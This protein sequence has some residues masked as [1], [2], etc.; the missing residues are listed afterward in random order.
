MQCPGCHATVAT[1]VPIG[2]VAA[3]ATFLGRADLLPAAASELGVVEAA[4]TPQLAPQWAAGGKPVVCVCL[5]HAHDQARPSGAV[6]CGTPAGS[7]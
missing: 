5:V 2:R 6:R 7:P 3:A 4:Q 1:G